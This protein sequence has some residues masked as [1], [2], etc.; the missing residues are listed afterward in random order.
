VVA[1]WD[2]GGII[3]LAGGKVVVLRLIIAVGTGLNLLGSVIGKSGLLLLARFSLPAPDLRFPN[4][5][6]LL[7]HQRPLTLTHA[8][9]KKARKANDFKIIV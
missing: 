3:L 1:G 2:F 9:G 5:L 7:L 6:T 4:R 8:T